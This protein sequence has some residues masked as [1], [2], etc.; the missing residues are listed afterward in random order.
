MSL[1]KGSNDLVLTVSNTQSEE[2]PGTALEFA[3]E[4]G[5][6]RILLPHPTKDP[7]D[8][9]N[10]SAFEKYTTFITICCFSW[11]ATVNSTSLT[12]ATVPLVKEFHQSIT[13]TSFLTVFNTLLLGVGNLFWVPLMKVIGKR[14][15]YL[16]ALPLV[17]AFNFWSFKATSYN[18]L[19]AARILSGFACAAADATAPQVVA[20]LFFT[21]ERGHCM[22]IFHFA[23]SAGIFVGPLLNAYIV[24]YAGWRWCCMFMGTLAAVIFVVAIFTIHETSYDRELADETLPVEAYAPKKTWIQSLSLTAGYD[25][26]G[27]F[28]KTF[29]QTIM[30]VFYPSVPL[31][32]L[33]IGSFIGWSIVVQ[34]TSSRTFTKPPYGWKTGSLGLLSLAGFI[35]AMFAFFVGGKLIDYIATRSSLRNHGRREPEARLPAMVIPAFFGPMGTLIFGL[36]VA[37]KVSWVGA[38]FGYAM[39]GFGITAASNVAVTYCVDSYRPLA[40]EILVI[41]FVIRNSIGCICS[42]FAADWEAATGIQNFFIPSLFIFI[43][44]YGKRIRMWTSSW[45]PMAR[46]QHLRHVD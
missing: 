39:Q 14:P 33:T 12:V 20:D 43:Y 18:S 21:H 41:I 19:L 13:R 1:G 11:L 45:G 5:G 36:C 15:V 28:F 4:N 29:Y 44:F 7:N 27:S 16:M 31:A 25:P 17:I 37:H 9:L 30:L 24:Q 35:G 6:Q 10:W 23:L 8:P 22:M 32:G 3:D 40:G 2:I 46:V 38:A 26:R 42:L 34:L